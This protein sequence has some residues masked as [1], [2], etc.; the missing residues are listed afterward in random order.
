MEIRFFLGHEHIETTMRY[1]NITTPEKEKAF[2][3]LKKMKNP[4]GTLTDFCTL[5][6]RSKKIQ[7]SYYVGGCNLMSIKLTAELGE[8][9]VISSLT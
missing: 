7:T 5:N 4:D 3:T 8:N 9:G 1:L 6:T 2:A